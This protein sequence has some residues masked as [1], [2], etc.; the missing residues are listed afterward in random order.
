MENE[1]T[2][3]KEQKQ[4]TKASKAVQCELKAKIGK[5]SLKEPLEIKS[6]LKTISLPASFASLFSPRLFP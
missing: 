6:I 4:F 5:I 2:A 3:L 1:L